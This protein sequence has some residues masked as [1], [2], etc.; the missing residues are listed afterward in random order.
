M[1]QFLFILTTSL[2]I[3]STKS[4][5]FPSPESSL[6]ILKLSTTDAQRK[7]KKKKYCIFSVDWKIKVSSAK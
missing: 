3:S 7:Q 6:K 2:Y 4:L 5:V 1:N